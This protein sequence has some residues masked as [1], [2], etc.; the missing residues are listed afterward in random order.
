MI[1]FWKIKHSNYWG[2]TLK[3]TKNLNIQISKKLKVKNLT[4]VSNLRKK[5]ARINWTR[6]KILWLYQIWKN[7]TVL[8]KLVDM[9]V[10]IPKQIIYWPLKK[11]HFSWDEALLNKLLVMQTITMSKLILIDLR[12][13]NCIE[14]KKISDRLEKLTVVIKAK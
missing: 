12:E 11:D 10:I 4:W 6:F 9:L 13:I 5:Q 7:N 1:K 3:V 14:F 8:N 2:K